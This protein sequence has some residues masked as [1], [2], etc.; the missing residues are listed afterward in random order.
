MLYI[1]INNHAKTQVH[2]NTWMVMRQ[3][4]VCT[5][6]ENRRLPRNFISKH[7]VLENIVQVSLSVKA[8]KSML[9]KG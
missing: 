4:N 6:I 5:K 7:R 1:E 9:L 3:R 8:T 2:S